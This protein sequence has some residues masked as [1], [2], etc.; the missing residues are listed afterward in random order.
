MR[1]GTFCSTRSREKKAELLPELFPT[2][3]T[4]QKPIFLNPSL[5]YVRFFEF[6]VFRFL[7]YW[8][9]IGPLLEPFDG[10]PQ[11]FREP[12]ESIVQSRFYRFWA[13]LI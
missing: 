3:P 13:F 1:F 10:V 6:S 12:S 4:Y 7:A 5:L 9:P 8:T 2:H 11:T